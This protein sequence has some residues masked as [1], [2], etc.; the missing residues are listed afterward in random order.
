[1]VARRFNLNPKMGNDLLLA[2]SGEKTGG[3]TMAN[4]VWDL[5]QS[6]NITPS[7]P[8]VEAY[9]RGLKERDIP[10]DDQRL[11]L[12]SRTYNNQRLRFGQGPGRSV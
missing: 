1:M 7:L 9:Y 10:A 12:V 3:Y 8:A 2:A 5:M 11:M 6:Q 4:Y